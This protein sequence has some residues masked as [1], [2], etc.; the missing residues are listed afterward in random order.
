MTVKLREQQQ[1]ES[2]TGREQYV[3]PKAPVQHNSFPGNINCTC[4]NLCLSAFHTSP[5]EQPRLPEVCSS[6][7]REWTLRTPPEAARVSISECAWK[8]QIAACS[9]NL[10][11]S[12]GRL[13]LNEPFQKM[14]F[15]E[16]RFKIFSRLHLE[17]KEG[18]QA[19]SREGT[20]PATC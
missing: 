3:Q 13:Q 15:D 18:L 12:P 17:N 4:A 20:V 2:T 5:I 16:E 6:G 1:T 11:R 9:K 8:F 19:R 10:E 14:G 7:G